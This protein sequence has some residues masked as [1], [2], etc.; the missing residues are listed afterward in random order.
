MEQTRWDEQ[1]K[2]LQLAEFA[3][4]SQ[5]FRHRYVN[6]KAAL[7]MLDGVAQMGII[8]ADRYEQILNKIQ[9]NSGDAMTQ[10]EANAYINEAQSLF[11]TDAPVTQTE[12]PATSPRILLIDDEAT[13]LQWGPILK[14]LF[15]ARLEARLE[16]ANSLD[17]GLHQLTMGVK[18]LS[19]VLLDVHF[20]EGRSAMELLLRQDE[21]QKTFE[22]LLTNIPIVMFS[23]DTEGYKVKTFLHAGAVDYFMK[24]IA[25]DRNPVSYCEHL[26]KVMKR[27]MR[28][29]RRPIFLDALSKAKALIPAEI[30]ARLCDEWLDDAIL[31]LST[32]PKLSLFCVA[33]AFETLV[34]YWG[35]KFQA[36]GKISVPSDQR[37]SLQ[38]FVRELSKYWKVWQAPY[39]LYWM[40]CMNYRHLIAHGFLNEI[41]YESLDAEATFWALMGLLNSPQFR[42]ELGASVVSFDRRNY[43]NK[44][45]NA[46]T[47]CGSLPSELQRL[48]HH[49]MEG[50]ANR[51]FPLAADFIEAA[52][53]LYTG[54]PVKTARNYL[55]GNGFHKLNEPQRLAKV[56]GTTDIE[57]LKRTNIIRSFTSATSSEHF[58]ALAAI[59]GRICLIEETIN[60]EN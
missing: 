29:A 60:Q 34:K 31:H 18:N 4:K 27:A 49:G 44:L 48:F 42:N 59:C 32:N 19:A 10:E 14:E 7:R 40:L 37:H 46:L 51:F 2:Q 38:P 17:G 41:P 1:K 53:N 54:K 50:D 58:N 55:I 11:P 9:Q 30:R 57:P 36:S 39:N 20:P 13:S 24:E 25:E 26:C 35:N 12:L 21:E 47:E 43:L 6:L 5:Q 45:L 52:L 23:V 3:R 8:N 33:S 16:W 22:P 56:F 15:A 28:E